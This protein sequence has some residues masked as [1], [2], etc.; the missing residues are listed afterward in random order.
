MAAASPPVPRGRRFR[1][2]RGLAAGR[3]PTRGGESPWYVRRALR[4]ETATAAP[5]RAHGLSRRARPLAFLLVCCAATTAI[6]CGSIPRQDADEPEG[7][8]PVEVSAKFPERQSLAKDSR[9]RIE[10][11]NTGEETIP[12]VNVEVDGF[13][14]VLRDPAN[15]SQTDPTVANPT[16]PVFVVEQAPVEYLRERDPQGQGLVDREVN[17]PYGKGTAYVNTYSLGELAPGDTA[18]FRWDLSAIDPGPYRIDWRVNAGL[19]GRAIAVSEDSGDPPEG[20]FEGNIAST[21]P[22]AK[23]GEDGE[24]VITSDGRRVRNQR[25]IELPRG[26]N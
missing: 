15:P 18:T 20:T 25:G 24:T 3:Q 4:A 14:K 13:S 11:T 19:D 26:S 16:R 1:A 7:E 10:V 17:P 9:L 6:G 8:F 5:R 21:A 2:G 23:V 22:L 12:E